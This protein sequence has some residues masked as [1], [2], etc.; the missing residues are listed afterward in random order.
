[1]KKI[2][3]LIFSLSI[4]YSLPTNPT[5]KKNETAAEKYIPC[6]PPAAIVV[7]PCIK[8]YTH[9]QYLNLERKKSNQKN[10]VCEK[11]RAHNNVP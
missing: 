8:C 10:K 9:Y 2:V 7:P 11:E 1:M 3:I 6:C 5:E 4:I